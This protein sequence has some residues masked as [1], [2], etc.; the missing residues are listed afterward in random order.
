VSARRPL[1]R[2]AL[3]AAAWGLGT[4]VT[5]I[6][7]LSSACGSLSAQRLAKL[8]RIG[9][10]CAGTRESRADR[11]DAFVQGLAD[12]GYVDGQTIA[13]E[14]RFSPE[15]VENQF[16]SLAAD[17]VRLSVDVIVVEASTPAAQA[18]KQATSTVPIVASNIALPV[19]AGLVASLSRPGGNLTALTSS[20]PGIEGKWLDL[21]R[22]VVPG[23]AR[24]VGLNDLTNDSSN[25]GWDALRTA[26]ETA[27]LLIERIDL[28]SAQ[29][30]EAAFEAPALGRAQALVNNGTALLAQ[31]RARLAELALQHRLP[32]ISKN[33][34]EAEAGLLMTYGPS[35]PA[36]SRRAAVYVDKILK[37]AR[38]AE[39]PVEQPTTLEFVVN[40]KTAQ[41]LG[42]TIPPDVA[43][44]VTEWI[45]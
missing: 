32:A 1:S 45:Q 34:P 13:I 43:A 9:Y 18:A 24:L 20:I 21:L 25:S 23:L 40:V 44:Q 7:L 26:A 27:K 3:L 28:R 33:R 31:R 2:R 4:S 41:A 10:L 35:L 42:I 19:Q 16:A 36:N 30:L 5:G 22:G 39:L 6:A 11:I 37:G 8:P 38:A 29:E 12:L 14:W 17:L 15:G